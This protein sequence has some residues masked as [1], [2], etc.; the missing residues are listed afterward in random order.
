MALIQ[1]TDKLSVGIADIDTQHK[2]LVDMINVLHEAMSQR[3][4]QE[5]L[6]KLLDEMAAYAGT[7]FAN[8]EQKMKAANY[9]DFAKHKP[10]HDA[11]A[12]K[13]AEFQKKV[14]AKQI[15]VT[16]ELMNFLKD[17]LVNH[18]CDVEKKY[19]PYLS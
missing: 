17:W 3:K 18:I 6:S 5:V 7:H 12:A 9:P 8:E 2:K 15:G 10:L 13:V 1:W 4:G 11:F 14:G 16:I 19:K